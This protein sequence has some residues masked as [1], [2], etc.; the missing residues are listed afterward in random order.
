MTNL[1]RFV[2]LAVALA[3]APWCAGET[4][5]TSPAKNGKPASAF[6]SAAATT[7]GG[8]TL[9][10]EAS[11]HYAQAQDA[12][13]HNEFQKAL[14]L[15]CKACLAAGN[16]PWAELY[17][18]EI[19][20]VLPWC[21]D[22]KPFL[23]VVEHARGDGKVAPHVSDL[24]RRHHGAW[25]A[26]RGEWA[27]AAETLKPLG[28]ITRWALA[29]PFDN[30]DKAGFA[31]AYDPENGVDFTQALAGRNRRV[32]WFQNTAVSYDGRMD[33][34]EVFEP[35][36]HVVAYAVTF[37]KAEQPGWRVL[38][39]GCAGACSVWV[40]DARA[41][42]VSDYNDF[43]ADKLVVPVHLR[44][45]WNKILLKTGVVEETAW[46]FVLRLCRPEGGAA[47]GLIADSSP[48]ALAAYREQQQAAPADAPPPERCALG[49][50]PLVDA[51]LKTAP[52]D[53]AL[54]A[55]RAM[56]LDARHAGDKENPEAPKV[57]AGAAALAPDRADLWLR[58]AAILPGAN[59]A[60]QAAETAQRLD[61]A[62][63]AVVTMLATLAGKSRQTLVAADYARQCRAR[64]GLE[65]M[66][67]CAMLLADA[68]AGPPP[69]LKPD[70][71][72]DNARSWRDSATTGMN[73]R[74]EAWR[75]MR[76]FTEQ[77]PYVPEGWVRLADLEESLTGRRAVLQKALSACGG[78]VRLREL[79]AV[80]L[81][82]MGR[83]ADAAGVLVAGLAGRPFSVTAVVAAAK[84]LERAGDAARA[85]QILND[86][87]GWAPENPELLGALARAA[88]RAGKKTEAAELCREILRLRPNSPQTSEYL[89]VLDT[90]GEGVSKFYAPYAIALADLAIPGA[91]AYP[92]DN[93]LNVL[94]QEV[95]RV[96]DNGTASRMVHRVVKLL[97][98]EG[99]R[100]RG[101]TQHSIFYDHERQV[102]DVFHAAVITAD[103]REVSRAEIRDHPANMSASTEGAERIMIYQEYSVK[104]V[105]F[106]DLEPGAMIDLRYTIRDTGGNLY[107][108][109]FATLFY[110]S[111][112][113]PTLKSQFVLD[114]PRG[115]NIQTRT[116]NTTVQAVPLESGDARRDVLKWELNNTPGIAYE[117]GM[118][119]V[120]DRLA[121]LQVT[122]MRSWQEL[123]AWYWNLAQ[124][125]L[126]ATPE[127]RA[128]VEQITRGCKTPRDK[129][130]AI[131][132][133]V[134]VNIRYLGIELGRYGFKPH[135]AGETFKALYGDCKDTAAL[136]VAMLRVAG[137]EAKLVLIRTVNSG[138]VPSDSLA[139]PNLFNHCI[140]YVPALDG[141]DYWVDC[142][143]DFY[144][145]G[146]VPWA[147]QEAQVLVVDAKGG[148]FTR[149]PPA[150][151]RENLVEQTFAASVQRSGAALLSLH[152]IRH[153]QFAPM[154]RQL[155]ETPGQFERFMKNYAARRF[156]GAEVAA[157]E[158]APRQDQGPMWMK[159]SLKVPALATQSGER[160]ALPAS[161]DPL[162][163]SP[164]HA[165]ESARTHDLELFFPWARKT[166]I[167]Y[168][169]EKGLAFAALPEEAAISEPFGKY[170][171]TLVRDGSKLTIREEFSLEQ[172]R[173]SVAQY[174]AFKAFCNRVD[175]LSDQKVLLEAK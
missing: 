144:R 166:E 64:F 32:R 76:A 65:R 135:R 7:L 108:D 42:A 134:I 107:G 1:R 118:P 15:L 163:L 137:I 155:A 18:E 69:S 105:V 153:G 23:R 77:H 68:L 30:R 124:D 14:E 66:G 100:E 31:T 37:V 117:N 33:L 52:D 63:P 26:P 157:L 131:H 38:R 119:P 12:L 20:A 151:A 24:V 121:M 125:Q 159:V 167:V 129:L 136:L 87:R 104:E 67:T 140:A 51:A 138:A 35:R 45:G 96:A 142:T 61:P 114:C 130:R 85:A 98:P 93:V 10:A 149:V 25:L 168:E 120:V 17:L 172:H 147:D 146:E 36:T 158:L 122:T 89:A 156:N 2:F 54:L 127:M 84:Q 111:D 60:R 101:L 113:Q 22:P 49:L 170:S 90:R 95:V 21:R 148:T 39:L 174:P 73:C 169:L 173:I 128:A 72:D 4:P 62:L 6:T 47:P 109:Y 110:L 11:R 13:A 123:G 88:D 106:R 162:T 55:A 150:A 80:E 145:L 40:N 139:L 41:G 164:R 34:A 44:K 5:A 132:D 82:A 16:S 116:F 81:N 79:R 9:S 3:A 91:D 126:A 115:L 171:R 175:S 19:S 70:E 56:L 152:D 99:L 29:G 112:D 46:A 94:N 86:A 78:G 92:R 103:G 160:L 161:L 154:Y 27:A 57:M 75:L 8:V 28:H 74:A 143:T 59:E 58:L 48:E 165:V 53:V 133:W 83:E 43:G 97:R 141:Q 50:L 102:V 71:E